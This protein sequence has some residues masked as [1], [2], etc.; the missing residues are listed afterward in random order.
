MRKGDGGA[1]QE[2]I[3]VPFSRLGVQSEMFENWMYARFTKDETRKAAFKKYE[4]WRKANP[5]KKD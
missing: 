1:T 2:L 5:V 3:L 4:E